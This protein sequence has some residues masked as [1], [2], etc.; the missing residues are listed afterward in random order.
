MGC[1]IDFNIKMDFTRKARF[2]A[3]GH[4]SNTLTAMTY[5]S[6]VSRESNEIG[7]MLAALNRLD[8]WLVIW[9]MHI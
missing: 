5:S 3:G 6:V 1:H 9:R 2:F 8:I 7:F 4:T